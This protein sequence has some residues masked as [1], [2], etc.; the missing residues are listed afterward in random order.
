M[1]HLSLEETERSKVILSDVFINTNL[2]VA[3][4]AVPISNKGEELQNFGY[5]EKVVE[6][7]S[8]LSNLLGKGDER[9]FWSGVRPLNDSLIVLSMLEKDPTKRLPRVELVQRLLIGD[10]LRYS[11]VQI[12]RFYRLT[13]LTPNESIIHTQL[14]EVPDVS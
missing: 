1:L 9:Y 10:L 12:R 2:V 7:L 5:S 14:V 6:I 8:E 11:L 13:V 4:P 3:S